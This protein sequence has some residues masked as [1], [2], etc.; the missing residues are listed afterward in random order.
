MSKLTIIV[1]IILV[2]TSVYHLMKLIQRMLIK[3]WDR[4]CDIY[5]VSQFKINRVR[6][7]SPPPPPPKKKYKISIDGN[8]VLFNGSDYKLTKLEMQILLTHINNSYK[9][10]KSKNNFTPFLKKESY[11]KLY[12]EEIRMQEVKERRPTLPLKM[13]LSD[14]I[15][16]DRIKDCD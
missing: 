3:W 7:E 5:G 8:P 11:Y 2:V 14:T 1:L 4:D 10:F 13:D 6:Y 15:Q 12:D 16:Q 9:E